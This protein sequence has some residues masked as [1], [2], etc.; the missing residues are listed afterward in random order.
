LA[1]SFAELH[2]GYQLKRM[3]TELADFQDLNF[4]KAS[5]LWRTI[6]H[7]DLKDCEST[8]L[9]IIETADVQALAGSVLAPLFKKNVP[10]LNLRPND[11]ELLLVALDGCT[12]EVIAKRLN[13]TVPA[14]KRRWEDIYGRI[15]SNPIDL[16][17]PSE[18]QRRNGRRGAQKRHLLLAYVRQHREELRPY[19]TQP[20]IKAPRSA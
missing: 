5:R 7:P 1:G 19:G 15:S 17:F 20:R 11:K 16:E 2:L 12:D 9:G 6:P 3:L 13:I 14:V 18:T 8:H 10:K 4:A